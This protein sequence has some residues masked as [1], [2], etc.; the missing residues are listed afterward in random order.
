[1]NGGLRFAEALKE[2]LRA[3]APGDGQ[4]RPIDQREDLAETSVRVGLAVIVVMMLI[5]VMMIVVMM[6]VV[7]LIVVMLIVVMLIVVMLIVVMLIVVMMIVMMMIVMMTIVV[8][9]I[10]MILSL[11]VHVELRRRDAGA[12]HPR[13]RDLVAREGQAAERVLQIVERQARVEQR[14]EQHVAGNA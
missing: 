3:I 4:R 8:M 14:P 10:L 5:V 13:G 7:M 12:Q 2:R 6:I 1:M 9:T 11:L